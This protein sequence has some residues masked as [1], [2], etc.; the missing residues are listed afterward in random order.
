MDRIG[1]ARLGFRAVTLLAVWLALAFA[2]S[3]SGPRHRGSVA[4]ARAPSPYGD[5]PYPNWPL[6][7]QDAAELMAG[8]PIER[9]DVLSREHAGA[10]LT[11]A[12]RL[13]VHF[14]EPGVE[15]VLKWKELPPG[16]LDGINNSPRKEIAAWA[17]QPLF[18]DP[19][20]YVVPP[21][22]AR[23]PPLALYREEFQAPEARP[24]I[25]GVDSVCGIASLWIKNVT[26]PELV[27][28]PSRFLV[29]PSYAYF[30]SNFNLLTY[31]I[32]HRD[33]R[34]GNFLVS[35]DRARRQVFA[36][37]N[38]VAFGG[39]FYNWFV[40]NWHII[41]VPALRKESVKRLRK[42]DRDDLDVL[43]VLAQFELDEE[44][45][46]DRVKPDKPL[47]PDRGVVFRD[48]T[49]QLG[50]TRAEIEAIWVRIQRLLKEID[51]GEIGT[52]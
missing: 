1:P 33:G 16:T 28:D 36:V 45:D 39:M 25:E 35:K 9:I 43:A 2:C 4:F 18:L 11:G 6:P 27:Y 7:P 29:D 20:D 44:R 46:L 40:P 50:L 49:L 37:D 14:S 42:L 24:S 17:I 23:C 15:L 21:S 52:F 13:Q 32:A 34:S 12:A 31:L 3:A 47:D 38:G 8:A 26:V 19:E 22:V 30:M 5:D 41:R 48:G 51:A 10:G